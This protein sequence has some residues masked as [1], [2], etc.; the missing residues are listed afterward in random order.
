MSMSRK[1]TSWKKSSDDCLKLAKQRYNIW[2]KWCNFWT[3]ALV[4]YCRS[5][6]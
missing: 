1:S 5:T 2:V 6:T 4:R 3:T